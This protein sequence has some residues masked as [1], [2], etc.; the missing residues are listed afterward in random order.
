MLETGV[1]KLLVLD[2]IDG[3]ILEKHNSKVYTPFIIENDYIYTRQLKKVNRITGEI[4]WENEDDL[5][6]MHIGNKYIYGNSPISLFSIDK[7]SGVKNWETIFG[8][9]I[10][11]VKTSEKYVV[12]RR[13]DGKTFILDKETGKK[14]WKFDSE[15]VY[16]SLEPMIVIG[17]ALI[18]FTGDGTIY[19]FDLSN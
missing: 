4:I 8:K 19:C 6:L 1:R 5:D 17:N 18:V 11:N 15:E 12:V 16:L 7:E 3:S 10:H 9:M 13:E 14:L 2:P